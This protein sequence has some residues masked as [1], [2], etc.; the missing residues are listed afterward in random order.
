MFIY[1]LQVT[2]CWGLFA[3]LYR[4]LLRKETFFR[5]NRLYL[6]TTAAAGLV[7]P[8]SG[9]WFQ[10]PQSGAVLPMADLPAVTLGLQQMEQAIAGWSWGLVVKGI[11][12][13]GFALASARLLWGMGC[14]AGMILR[15][16]P[17]CLADGSLVIR[18][19]KA[20]LPFSFFRWVFIPQDIDYQEDFQNM[21][22][23]ERAHVRGWHS[24]DVLW[25]ELLCV[26]LW[27][28]PLIHWYRKALR[29]VH[30]YLADKAAARSTDRKRYGLLLVR[31][32]QGKMP[33]VFANHFFQSPLKQRIDM[34]T[35]R[36]SAPANVWKYGLALPLTALFL[37]VF[38]YVPALAFTSKHNAAE[39]RTPVAALGHPGVTRVGLDQRTTAPAD[40]KKTGSYAPMAG[41]AGHPANLADKLPAFPGGQEALI[42]FMMTHLNYPEEDRKAGR[43]GQ[44][45]VGFVVDKEGKI[46]QV[47]AEGNGSDASAAMLEEAARIIKSM[48][49][50][51]PAEYR[52]AKVKCRLSIPIKFKLQ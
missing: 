18:T 6:L 45:K 46:E 40:R 52:G 14:L 48:P 13:L 36:N 20:L 7:L 27:F 8:L 37:L 44:V 39:E 35:R 33:V 9:W 43:T 16:R 29:N 49:R 3:L 38:Q 47:S 21:L 15:N 34:L 19:E 10:V 42:Q 51:E 28:H 11:Y 24:L 17:E 5:A 4:L 30:E 26:V 2:L 1:L 31:Q 25:M 50:W 41:Y 22:A 23:H 12:W 32:V